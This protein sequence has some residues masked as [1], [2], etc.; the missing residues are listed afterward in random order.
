MIS[1]RRDADAV[2][3]A[4][5]LEDVVGQLNVAAGVAGCGR[6]C[7]EGRTEVDGRVP[8]SEGA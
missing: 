8:A 5:R 3:D 2:F 1:T 6:G 7:A 4:E